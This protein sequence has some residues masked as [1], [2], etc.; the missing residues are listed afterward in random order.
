VVVA[1]AHK[2]YA[3]LTETYFQ[4][5]LAEKGVLMDVKGIYRKNIKNIT[6]MSL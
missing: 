4:S 2:E 3:N 6:Y 5:L 1:V